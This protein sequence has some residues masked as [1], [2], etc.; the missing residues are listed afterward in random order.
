MTLTSRLLSRTS[1]VHRHC[2]QVATLLLAG[3]ASVP[4]LGPKPVP[5]APAQIAAEQSLA[6]S[7]AAVWPGEGWWSAYGDPQLDQLIAEGLRAG[8]AIR[9]GAV[10]E[11]RS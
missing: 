6:P 9:R 11:S 4:Q 5:L 1:A 7:A 2:I 3:C 10:A 8:A